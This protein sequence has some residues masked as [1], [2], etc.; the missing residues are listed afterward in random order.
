MWLALVVAVAASAG[1]AYAVGRWLAPAMDRTLPQRLRAEAATYLRALTASADGD[2]AAA[3]ALL[4]KVVRERTDEPEV[5]FAL[6]AQHRALGRHERAARIHQSLAVRPGLPPRERARARLELAQDYRR[7]GRHGH[8]AAEVDV[9][10]EERADDPLALAAAA[11]VYEAAGQWERAA[12]A[13]GR[14]LRL[15]RRDPAVVDRIVHLHAAA[16][17]RACAAG[18]ASAAAQAAK[19]APRPSGAGA[20]AHLAHA[21]ATVAAAQ[22]DARAAV[23]LWRAALHEAPAL[24]LRMWPAM[25]AALFARGELGEAE[26]ALRALAQEDPRRVAV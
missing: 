5:Y 15:W 18:N 8:A 12:A 7:L 24:A 3:H 21:R 4:E 1:V 10:L 20:R 14:Q 11:D 26:S 22:G 23:R 2:G 16:A 6:A 9:A 17:L 19:G 13:L 25:R